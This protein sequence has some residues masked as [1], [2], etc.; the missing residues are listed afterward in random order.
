MNFTKVEATLVVLA[1]VLA[2]IAAFLAGFGLH[3]V[4]SGL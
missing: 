2:M 1:V 3:A 4:I